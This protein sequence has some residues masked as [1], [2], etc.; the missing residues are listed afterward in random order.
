MKNTY[1]LDANGREE[2]V[3]ELASFPCACGGSVTGG[4][5][6]EGQPVLLHTIP[7]CREFETLD[8]WAFLAWLRAK[9]E[10]R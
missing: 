5:T 9:Y 10:A 3:E 1:T 8:L 6:E 7:Y 2:T 4:Y